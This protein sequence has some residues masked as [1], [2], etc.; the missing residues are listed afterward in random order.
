MARW[1]AGAPKR[2]ARAEQRTTRRTDR[3]TAKAYKNAGM[4]PPGTAPRSGRTRR[5]ESS[6]ARRGQVSAAQAKALRRSAARHGVRMGASA[7]LAGGVGLASGIWNWRRPGVASRHVKAVWLRLANRARRIREIRDAAILGKGK[8][9]ETSVPGETVNDPKRPTEKPRSAPG[10]GRS[11]RPVTL[12][13]PKGG[14]VSKTSTPGLARLSD[15]AEVMLQAASTFDPEQMSEFEAL[16]DDLPEAMAMVQETIRVL[17]E[18]ADEK[19]PVEQVVTEEIGEGYRA[20]NR[21]IDALAEV[22]T[23]YRKAHAADIERHENPRKGIEGE[24][25]WNV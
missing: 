8:P 25:K 10:K 5:A 9:G 7:V 19:L 14:P 3:G 17:A 6:S 23:V 13:A 12:D 15:A 20:M 1:Q 11:A 18:L 22:G 21:V 16:I 2:T 24:R 4:T